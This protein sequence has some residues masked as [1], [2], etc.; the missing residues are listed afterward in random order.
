MSPSPKLTLV[1]KASSSWSLRH[2]HPRPPK[3][4]C[5]LNCEFGRMVRRGESVFC[6]H[7]GSLQGR[8]GEGCAWLFA[9]G[10][11]KDVQK[12]TTALQ[13]F[14]ASLSHKSQVA[15]VSSTLVRELLR[16]GDRHLGGR[17]RGRRAFYYLLLATEG[18]GNGPGCFQGMSALYPCVGQS[19]KQSWP[20]CRGQVL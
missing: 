13:A 1:W 4:G 6:N 2:P 10:F 14:N 9:E 19:R 8:L 17:G 11:G 3:G 5:M 12:C 16:A 18:T 7:L 20:Q 15:D